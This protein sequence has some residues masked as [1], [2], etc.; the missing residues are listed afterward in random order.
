MHVVGL[1]VEM[2]LTS[3][4]EGEKEQEQGGTGE[5]ATSGGRGYLSRNVQS[6]AREDV[7]ARCRASWR[8]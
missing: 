4:E 3:M 5:G 8:Q 6:H 7:C 2:K 1:G